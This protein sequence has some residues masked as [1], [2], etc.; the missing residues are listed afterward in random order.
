MYILPTFVYNVT[1]GSYRL[2]IENS[3]TTS[4]QVYVADILFKDKVIHN[5]LEIE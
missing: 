2:G 5:K 4:S 3:Q 1:C